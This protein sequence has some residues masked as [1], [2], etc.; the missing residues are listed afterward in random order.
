MR[1]L[2]L[3]MVVAM[4]GI[5]LTAQTSLILEEDFESGTL[6]PGVWADGTG[7]TPVV[8]LD[9]VDHGFVLNFLSSGGSQQILGTTYSLPTFEPDDVLLVSIDVRRNSDTSWFVVATAYDQPPSGGTYGATSSVSAMWGLP[10]PDYHSGLPG[11]PWYPTASGAQQ[12]FR[13]QVPSEPTSS[14]P[15]GSKDD[16]LAPYLLDQGEWYALQLE[17]TSEAFAFLANRQGLLNLD[18]SQLY[19]DFSQADDWLFLM[20]DGGTHSW[21]PTNLSVDNILILQTKRSV[22]AAVDSLGIPFEVADTLYNTYGAEEMDRCLACCGS[23]LP[24]Y[25]ECL[26]P[27]ADGASGHLR[28]LDASLGDTLVI[29]LVNVGSGVCMG[30]PEV[31]AGLSYDLSWVPEWKTH[32]FMQTFPFAEVCPGQI[33]LLEMELP[34]IP[35]EALLALTER[36]SALWTGYEDRDP[37]RDYIGLIVTLGDNRPVF[38]FVEIPE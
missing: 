19:Y 30:V 38:G 27:S 34:E 25:M 8:A 13:V 32:F 16:H 2:V 18:S 37:V 1:S 23:D 35:D 5:P 28:L 29:R 15:S 20:G 11:D 31:I 22:L 12:G 36:V 6:D 14:P 3:M 24:S 7:A 26:D 4:V 9:G 10:F 17:Y 33:L 21:Q